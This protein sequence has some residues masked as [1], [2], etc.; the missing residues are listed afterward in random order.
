MK[1]FSVNIAEQKIL[2]RKRHVETTAEY[3][4]QA[5]MSILIQGTEKISV[6]EK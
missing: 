2:L 3:A 6:V 1:A 5:S 4:L